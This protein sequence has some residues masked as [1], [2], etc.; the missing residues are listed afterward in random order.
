MLEDEQD[1]KQ[2]SNK[3]AHSNSNLEAT[4]VVSDDMPCPQ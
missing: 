1:V 2:R 4:K 3:K